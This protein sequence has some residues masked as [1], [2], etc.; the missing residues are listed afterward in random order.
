MNREDGTDMFMVADS[1]EQR[2]A[3]IRDFLRKYPSISLVIA[4]TYFE[5]TLSRAL[6]ALSEKPNKI[7]REA[8]ANTY[9]LSHYRDLWWSELSY[10]PNAQ[11]LHQVVNDWEHVAQAFKER[12]RLVHGRDR[13]TRNMAKPHV[14]RLL[15]A[16]S[17]IHEYCQFNGVNLGRRLPVRRNLKQSKSHG[18][19]KS[20][21][22]GGR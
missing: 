10:L 16:V 3:V 12:N 13:H 15:S 21:V 8:L 1:L 14:E 2:A 20:F 4:A 17:D 18:P 7:V 19:L 11:R 6:V 9:G 5:W 22:A